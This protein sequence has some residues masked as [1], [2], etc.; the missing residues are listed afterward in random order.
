MTRIKLNY[1][2]IFHF[3]G[4]LLLFNGGF[5]AIATL[6]SLIY[7]DGVTFKLL[8][9]ALI[10]LLI[11]AALMIGTRKHRKEM[12]KREGYIV[13]AFGWIVM[14]L[15]GTLPYLI[16]EA[17]PLFTDAFF[18]TIS[19]Y[20]TTGASILN[21][22]ESVPK[23]VL[24]WR[25]TTHWI[26]GMGIIVLA[27][28]ILPLLGIGGMQLFA[29]EAPGPS[30]DKLHPRITDTAKRLWLIYVGYTIAET[31]LLQVA[32]MSFFD[33]IN[34]ALSTLSTGG[35]STKNDSI[36]HWNSN[37]AIQ[38][39]IM[40]FMFLAG[41]NFVLSYFAFKG[42]VQKIIKDEEFKIYF[43]FI[44]VFTAIAALIIY[45]NAD[46][47]QSS[48]DHPMVMGEFESAVRHG[49]FQVLAIITTTGFV[50]ADYTLWTPFLTVFFF[51]LMFL[52]G[53]AGSTA[54]GI[55]VVRHLVLIKNGFLEFKRALHPNAILPVRYNNRSVSGDIVFNILGFFIVYMLFFIFGAL[56]FSMFQMDFESAIGLSASSLGNVGPALGDFGPTHNYAA[57]PPLAKWWASFLMLLGRLELFTVLILLTPFFWRNR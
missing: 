10:T 32:G 17:I 16:T 47:S 22:I 1:K 49:L 40:V 6:I 43:K 7:K 34:H 52:G 3:F 28:A 27:I 56:V 33:A 51:G 30:G 18:E 26:G 39:I 11:G 8:L 57:L 5:M 50:T 20:T 48:I 46:P 55:K 2:I 53:S 31:L 35:F 19:G 29:A 15:T 4:L 37:P 12:N 45:F 42:K 23:G 36:A 25:S 21:D 24:F 14:S 44:I 13:V 38:Y 9:S 41:T 54:G